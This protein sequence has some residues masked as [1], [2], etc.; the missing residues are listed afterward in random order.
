MVNIL[1]AIHNLD[2]STCLW[3]SVKKRYQYRKV[4]YLISK[5]GDG[6][7]YIAVG[8]L[9]FFMGGKGGQL[10]FGAGVAAYVLELIAYWIL[11]NTIKRDRPTSMEIFQGA[12]IIPSDKFSFP[13][14]HTAAAFVFATLC[15]H[16]YPLF[17]PAAY[18]W[19]SLIGASRVCLG[20]HF[21][22][23]IVAGMI[24]GITSCWCAMFLQRIFFSL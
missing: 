14:G 12:W 19:A 13:S 22:S 4:I 18:V 23:D 10:F 15:L 24:L 21:P 17:A 2:V 9:L 3:V 5:T 16:F 7:L 8:L 1:Q 11:K 20:V 6:P